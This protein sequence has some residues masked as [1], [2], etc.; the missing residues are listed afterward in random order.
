MLHKDI[1]CVSLVSMVVGIMCYMGVLG[2]LMQ[3]PITTEAA[4]MFGILNTAG[5]ITIFYSV[6]LMELMNI[7][8][9]VSV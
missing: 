8:P 9:P 3:H 2:I 4:I 5:F 7:D 1:A 6:L